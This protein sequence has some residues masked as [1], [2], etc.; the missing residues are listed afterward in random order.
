MTGPIVFLNQANTIE[1]SAGGTITVEAGEVAVLGNLTTDGGAIR[2][3]ADGNI[4]IG[5]LNAGTGNVTVQSA[6]GILLDGN[7]PSA[8]NVV[9]GSTTLSGN[10]PTARQLQLN[11]EFAIAA[12][13]AAS[14]EAASAQT[15]A[16]AFDAQ[17]PIIT[18]QV[19]AWTATLAADQ[20]TAN[21]LGRAYNEAARKLNTLNVTVQSLLLVDTAICVGVDVALAIAD[22]RR[23]FLLL[24]MA[25]R[26]RSTRF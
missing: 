5:R 8:V 12:A 14:A 4:T 17:I 25:G 1:A 7:G 20:Q 19:A 21:A 16:D 9:A 15:L 22:P 11:E 6:Q 3:T 23:P 2:V 10:A 26:A 24:A 18:S 13:A